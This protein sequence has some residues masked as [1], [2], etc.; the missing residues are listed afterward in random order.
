MPKAPD[1]RTRLRDRS[2]LLYGNRYRLEVGAY[3]AENK[4]VTVREI[5]AHLGVADSLVRP[6][7]TRLKDAGL[8]QAIPKSD[9]HQYFE[10]REDPYF[11]VCRREVAAEREAAV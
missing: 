6:N 7:L 2:G 1:A 10:R 3:I 11:E 8:V 4:V 5:A 9:R